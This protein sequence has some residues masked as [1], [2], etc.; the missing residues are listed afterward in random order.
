MAPLRIARISRMAAGVSGAREAAGRY[1]KPRKTSAVYVECLEACA[2]QALFR[3]VGGLLLFER[4]NLHTVEL[5]FLRYLDVGREMFFCRLLAM[6][7][8][9]SCLVSAATCRTSAP[10]GMSGAFVAGLLGFAAGGAGVTGSTL[11]FAFTVF[12]AGGVAGAF[13]TG[14]RCGSP[15]AGLLLP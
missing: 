2:L 15:L 4:A 6:E 7:S 3:G 1:A 12:D 13:G 8:A 14:S 5:V 9:S 10:F 11:A